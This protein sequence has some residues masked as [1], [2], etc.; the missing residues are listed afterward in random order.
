MNIGSTLTHLISSS[1]YS[2]VGGQCGLGKA[3][4]DNEALARHGKTMSIINCG[5]NDTLKKEKKTTRKLSDLSKMLLEI[6]LNL[7]VP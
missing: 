1:F 6:K 5:I 3:W 7:N 2:Y 4:Q